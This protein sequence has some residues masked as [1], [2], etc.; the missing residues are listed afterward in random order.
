[1]KTAR[2]IMCSKV[3]SVRPGDPV[4]QVVRMLIRKGFS[5][6]PVVDDEGHL[7]GILSERDCIEAIAGAAFHNT[8]VETVGQRMA[9][10]VVSVNP[11]DDIFRLT[12]AFVSHPYRRLPVV[13]DG[14]LVGLIT[15]RDLMAALDKLI[16]SPRHSRTEVYDAIAKR[17][18]IHN[19]FGDAS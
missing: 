5:G 19:P 18:G 7:V 3:L 9:R 11:A 2:D 1:M 12:M 16:A 15:R 17:E 6:A 13:E 4:V 10:D 14:R 8:P